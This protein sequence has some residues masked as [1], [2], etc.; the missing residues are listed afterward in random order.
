MLAIP[1]RLTML[2]S[3]A[4]TRRRCVSAICRELA[5]SRMFC[6]V[7]PQWIYPAADSPQSASN[8]RRTG[9]SGCWVNAIS[10]DKRSVSKKRTSAFSTITAAA[11]AGIIPSSACALASAASTVSHACKLAVSL[12]TFFASPLNQCAVMN[13][14]NIPIA[15]GFPFIERY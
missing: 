6:V 3:S 14:S 9:T 5:V 12:Q 11:D 13:D 2:S 15:M 7:A 8:W 10:L 1:D 4:S